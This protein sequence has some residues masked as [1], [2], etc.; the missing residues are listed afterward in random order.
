MAEEEK[1]L[2]LAQRVAERLRRT[3]GIAPAPTAPIVNT[4]LPVAAPPQAANVAANAGFANLDKPAA[5][6]V[7]ASQPPAKPKRFV[8]PPADPND[9]QYVN[10]DLR[11]LYSEGFVVP[12]GVSNQIAEEFRVIKRPLL[13]RAF[14]REGGREKNAHVMMVTSARPGE[15]KTFTAIN[16]SMSIASE[17]DLN[18]LLIDTDSH[19]RDME[20]RLGLKIDRGLLDVLADESMSISDVILRTN[21]ANFSIIPCGQRHAMETELLASQRMVDVVEDLAR[22]YPDRVI[23][24]DTVPALASSVASVL[25]LHVGQVI[26]VVEAETTQRQAVEETIALVSGC[27]HVSLLLNKSRYKDADSFGYYGYYS[28]EEE[29]SAM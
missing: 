26:V 7:R 13:L 22:R 5:A 4:P 15:G 8:V 2:D 17:P 1:R 3:A 9:P 6:P 27:K 12:Q 16:L 19:N 23:I 21:V 14:P 10:I 25:A 11:K 29:V 20:T 24:F 18:V 28:K